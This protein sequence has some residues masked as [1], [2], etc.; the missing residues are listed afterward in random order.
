VI[1]LYVQST[2]ALR[3]RVAVQTVLEVRGKPSSK[4]SDRHRD[5]IRYDTRCYFSVHSIAD[6]SQLNLPRGSETSESGNRKT[7]K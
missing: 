7:K 6:I 1:G 3:P 2:D 4:P 5:T